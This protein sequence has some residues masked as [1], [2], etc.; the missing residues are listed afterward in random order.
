M[1][2]TFSVDFSL[3]ASFD[4]AHDSALRA[5]NENNQL[6]FN[7]L[8]SSFVF[9]YPLKT[10]NLWFSDLFRGYTKIKGGSNRLRFYWN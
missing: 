8:L 3:N 2:G 10:G 9:L 1:S 7:P 6:L 4:Y 5:A